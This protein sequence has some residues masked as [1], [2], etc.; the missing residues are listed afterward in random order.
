MLPSLCFLEGG[1][2]DQKAFF[3]LMALAFLTPTFHTEKTPP[4][5][6]HQLRGV[7]RRPFLAKQLWNNQRATKEH[8][9]NSR[10]FLYPL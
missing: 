1:N 5:A 8:Q 3:H 4:K 6:Q 7:S 2:L 9:P 10:D